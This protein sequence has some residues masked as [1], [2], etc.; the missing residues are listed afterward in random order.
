LHPWIEAMLINMG[1]KV[2]TIEYN[3]HETHYGDTLS[4]KDYFEYFENFQ[5]EPFDAI[6]TY[7]SVE[8]SGL[9]RY[10]DPL[11]PN[12]DLKTMEVIYNNMKPGGILVWGAPVGQDMLVWNSHR[13]YGKHRLPLIFDKFNN[14]AKCFCSVSLDIVMNKIKSTKDNYIQPVLVTTK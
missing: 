10:G 11:D 7:S 12:G 6:V 13:I 9:G 14:K 2:T 1:N 3:V 5:D 8:H 4:C